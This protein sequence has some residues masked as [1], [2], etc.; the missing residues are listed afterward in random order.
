M[1]GTGPI[2][3]QGSKIQLTSDGDV[4][5]EASGSVKVK[6]SSVGVN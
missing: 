5:V 3:V 4:N 6:G 1:K 2:E